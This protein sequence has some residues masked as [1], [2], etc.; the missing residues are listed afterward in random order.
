MLPA[1]A[2][3]AVLVAVAAFGASGTSAIAAGSPCGH[4][5]RAPSWHHIVVIAFENHSYAQILGRGAPASEFTRLAGECGSASDYRAVHYPRSLPN[6]LGATSGGFPVT[7]DCLPGPGCRSGAANIFSQVG[8]RNWRS[9]AESMPR[10]CD[11][12]D[13]SLFVPRHVPAIY[14]TR[15]SRTSCRRNVVPL[16]SR[17]PELKRMFTWITPNLQHD[18][19]DGTPA[20][21]GSWLQSFLEGPSGLLHRRPYTRGHTAIFIWFDSAGGSGSARTPIP[22]IVISPSTPARVV[23]RPLN[24]YSALRA[25]ESMLRVHCAGNACRATGLRRPFRL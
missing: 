16:G 5:R 25:W 1:R 10:P 20:Q 17:P 14:Y 12:A 7:S 4:A 9:F 6:Y 18:M 15:V 13:T 23:T 24:H 11:P 3:V 22:F 21:A 8:G 19:H 2:A